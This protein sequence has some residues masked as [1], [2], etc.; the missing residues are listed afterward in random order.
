MCACPGAP[1]YRR[2]GNYKKRKSV[3]QTVQLKNTFA[4]KQTYIPTTNKHFKVI[5]VASVLQK[6]F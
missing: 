2:T 6:K 4:K 1:T 5:H 3:A